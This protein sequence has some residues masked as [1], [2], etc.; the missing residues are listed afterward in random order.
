MRN[1]IVR[2]G[3]GIAVVLILG[4]AQIAIATSIDS[5]SIIKDGIEYYVQTNKS[6]YNLGENVEMLYRITNLKSENIT[7]GFPHSPEYQFW[8]EKDDDQIWAAIRFRTQIPTAFTLLPGESKEFPLVPP[9]IWNMHDSGNN[10]VGL[11]SYNVIGGL[12]GSSGQY[13]YTKVAVSIEIVPEP[14]T[15]ILFGMGFVKIL[16]RKKL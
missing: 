7:F 15:L 13:D 10:M 6:V 11:G 8:I 12:Y 2:R 14:I 5:N 3:T 4:F 1:L 9:L 16:R